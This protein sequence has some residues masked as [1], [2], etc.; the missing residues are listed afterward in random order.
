MRCLRNLGPWLLARQEKA[1]VNRSQ[2][3]PARQQFRE[4]HPHCSDLQIWTSLIMANVESQ[5]PMPRQYSARWVTKSK[6]YMSSRRILDGWRGVCPALARSGPRA[7][8]A[9]VVSP[10][11]FGLMGLHYSRVK[12]TNRTGTMLALVVVPSGFFSTTMRS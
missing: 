3:A 12:G 4:A 9:A 8:K 2:Q 5:D 10:T 1:G 6:E 11:I 7:V